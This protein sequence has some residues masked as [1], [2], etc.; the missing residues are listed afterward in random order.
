MGKL[1][2]QYLTATNPDILFFD[3]AKH[4]VRPIPQSYLDAISNPDAFGNNGY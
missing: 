1:T 3:E 2:T 4:Q